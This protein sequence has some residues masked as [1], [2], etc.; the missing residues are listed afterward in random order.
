MGY[1]IYEVEEYRRSH[2]TV[3]EK[4]LRQYISLSA[5]FSVMNVHDEK[6]KYCVRCIPHCS[7]ELS[8]S[9][10]AATNPLT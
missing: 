6:G 8:D 4:V 5:D 3:I 2:R 1:G 7:S 10:K 9:T